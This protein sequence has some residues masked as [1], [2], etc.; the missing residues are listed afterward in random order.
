MPSRTGC[1]GCTAAPSGSRPASRCSIRPTPRTCSTCCVTSSV[2]RRASAA[3]RARRHSRR[4]TPGWS[5]PAQKLDAVIDRH[6]PWC[7]RRGRRHPRDL[8]G[9]HGAQ[10]RAA[11]ARLRRPAAVLAGPRDL[12][13]RRARRSPRCS[14]TSWS[15]SI[16]T[17]TR[18][19]RTSSRR[20]APTGSPR[21]L[22]VVGDDAQAIYGFRAAT[23]RNILE[24]P[25]R[26]PGAAVVKLER[27]YRSTTPILELSNAVIALSP[28]R[29]EKTL[30]TER[31]DGQ[32]VTLQACADDRDQADAV[33]RAV[34]EARERGT[35]LKEQAVLFR[36]AHHSDVLEIEL[37]TKEHPVREVRGSQVPG[38][39]TRE[40]RDLAAPGPREP[41]RRG[42]VVP[43]APA[44]RRDGAGGC[45]PGDGRDRCPQR[46][47]HAIGQLD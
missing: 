3:S 11:D 8:P 47:R 35:P 2:S 12:A 15:T 7:H 13:V 28:Q 1:S 40:G 5:T 18:S 31:T 33:C 43:G 24:F 25:E 21:N 41:A 26:F 30:W 46:G 38:G 16:R 27:N 37:H 42:C 23:V 34:L 36:A 6:Y 29:H 14:T 10:A 39:R 22:T 19:R 20:C 32:T 17:R 9:V 44:A 4:S 45:A